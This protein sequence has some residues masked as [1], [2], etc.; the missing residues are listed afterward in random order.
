MFGGIMVENNYKL[1]ARYNKITNEMMNEIIKNLSEEE[2]NRNFPIFFRSVHELCSHIY[3]GD[4]NWLKRFKLL[5]EFKILNKDLFRKNYNFSEII[6]SNSNEYILLRT[7]LDDII[8]EFVN[9]LTEK[10]FGALLKFTDSQGTN[11]EKRIDELLIHSF[12]HETHHRGMISL[13]L[14]MLGKP[15][16]YSS[17][18]TKN[19]NE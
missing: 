14:E 16:D 10:D 7:E 2:W 12:N 6:F 18:Y 9:E 13:V 19:L 4:F 1:L 17:M 3:I 8:I 5:R 11:F 15:N